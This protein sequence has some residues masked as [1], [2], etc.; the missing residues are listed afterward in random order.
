[1]ADSDASE[2]VGWEELRRGITW[3]CLV[4]GILPAIQ[5]AARFAITPGFAPVSRHIGDC[6]PF[7]VPR[8]VLFVLTSL[9]YV[10][11]GGSMIGVIRKYRDVIMPIEKLALIW[12]TFSA[13]LIPFANYY[14]E[15][16]SNIFVAGAVARIVTWLVPGCILLYAKSKLT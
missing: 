11:I 5:L 9:L 7:E 13:L 15:F 3:F 6:D 2:N 4:F 14:D 8:V 10:V 16:V 12:M 1:V